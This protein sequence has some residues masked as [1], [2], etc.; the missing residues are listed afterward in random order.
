MGL[1]KNLDKVR[2]RILGM[3][4]LP[5]IREVFSEVHREKSRKKVMLGE[6]P[7][8]PITENSALVARGIQPNSSDNR[9]KRRPWCDHCRKT[10]HT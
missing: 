2:G 5:N 3:K 6:Y 10:G 1:N 9:Q 8:V 7:A 4:P